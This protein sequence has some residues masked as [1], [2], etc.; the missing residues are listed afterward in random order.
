MDCHNISF[1]TRI[2][3]IPCSDK[4][5]CLVIRPEGSE[6]AIYARYSTQVM[7]LMKMKDLH[8]FSYTFHLDR[9]SNTFW[10]SQNAMYRPS[11]A[12]G[13]YIVSNQMCSTVR[14]S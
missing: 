13:I 1:T 5:F 2:L 12:S 14:L 8:R 3:P 4:L 9:T 11:D 7:M 10:V 6:L